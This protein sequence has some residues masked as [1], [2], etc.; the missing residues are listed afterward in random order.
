MRTILFHRFGAITS[1]RLLSTAVSATNPTQWGI[2]S[3]GKISSDFCQALQ[4]APNAIAA[5][6]AARSQTKARAFA[7]RH[8]IPTAYGSYEA[9]L[10]DPTIDVVYVG[11]IADQHAALTEQA[12]LARK[13]VVVEKPLSL[14]YTTT[15]KLTQLAR[16]EHVFLMEGMWTRFFPAMRRVRELMP[17][18][19][20]VS[21][22]QADFGW[23]TAE[24]G[25]NDRIWSPESGGMTLDIGMYLAQLGQVV[26]PGSK[27]LDLQAMGSKENGVDH[28]GL[29]NIMY[30]GGGFLQFYVTGAANTEERVL[31]QGTKG[32]I[33]IDPPAHVPQCVR[34][35]MDKGRN[36]NSETVSEFPLP[37]DSF[38]S[39]NYPGSI[40]F[41]YQIEA[42]GRA[43]K[44]G[45]LECPD[46][47]WEDSLQ[48]ASMLDRIR[49]Q[50]SDANWNMQGQG[51]QQA[52]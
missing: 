3:A 16:Q 38:A 50:L 26:W 44:A 52:V 9:M 2:L 17:Q 40:G 41:V 14:D 23:S 8:N 7:A 6:V 28:T 32:R 10:Q 15:K 5:A 51:L 47:K 39:W 46:F 45:L 27:V 12:I 21:V 31:I 24:C 33:I 4:V 42:V 20:E 30:E 43:L 37:D 49:S 48:V 34:L 1:T 19:G 22:I 18:I 36:D 11:S 13:P 35:V 29:A 25:P